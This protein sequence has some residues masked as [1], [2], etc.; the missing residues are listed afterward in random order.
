MS[1]KIPSRSQ[2]LFALKEIEKEV[3]RVLGKQQE[4]I[5][6][7][8]DI[9]VFRDYIASCISVGV[10]AID[11]ETNN[12]LDPLTCKLMGL[13]LY[14]PGLKAAYIPINHRDPET[15]IRLGVQLTE[16]DVNRELQKVLEAGIKIIMHNGKFDYEV[17]KCTCDICVEPHWD[18]MV[19]TRLLNEN[20]RYGLKEQYISKIDKTQEKYNIEKLFKDVQYADVKP[21]IFALYSAMDSFMTYKLYEYQ[22][23]LMDSEKNICKL[24]MDI[25]MP[26]VVIVA[27]MELCGALADLNY[28]QK[29]KDKYESKLA[30]IDTLLNDEILKL[31]SIISSWKVSESGLERERVFPPESVVART[32][33][34]VLEKR[35]PLLDPTSGL[36]Y[37]HGKTYASQ[38]KDPINLSSPKQLAILL[39]KV[40]GAN[41]VN[42]RKPNGTGKHEIEAIKYE[43]ELTLKLLEAKSKT[44]EAKGDDVNKLKGIASICELL[45]KRRQVEKIITTYLNPV[46]ALANHWS[47]GKI[48]FHLNQLGARTGRFTSGG[49]WKFYDDETPV[50]IQGMNAQNLPAENHEIRLMFKAE[51]GRIFVGGDISQQE[52]KITAHISLDEN[53]LQVYEEGKDIYASIAQSIFKNNYEDN[54]EFYDPEK[55]QIN[56]EGK[57]R[58]KVGKVIILATMYGMG[59][60]SVARKLGITT[61]EADE[62]L[63]AFYSQYEGVKKA[64]DFSVSYCKKYGFV[65]D[66]AGRKRRL[67][68]IQ[69]PKY[70]TMFITEP[71]ISNK[72]AE[73]ILRAV[74]DSKEKLSKEE[75]AELRKQAKE[76]NIIIVSNEEL[77]KKAERQ[78]FNA[79]I[80]GGAAT[81]T[82]MIMVMVA[83]DSLIKKL[84]GRIVFQIHDELIL[85]CPIENA[86]TIK[87]RLK[88]IMENSSTAVEIVLPMKCDMTTE[89]RWGEDTMT[90]EL[91]VAHQELIAEGAENPLDKL[92]EEFCNF[93][94]ESICKIIDSDNEVL[95]FEW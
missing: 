2:V 12:S 19:A 20:E 23:P 48:R 46:P 83:R 16:E 10:I 24:F 4:N 91:R 69:L 50:T 6:T 87:T 7:I 54:L 36:R 75:L 62:M 68:N 53:M 93:P 31:E 80:Q 76:N 29:L 17:L 44:S 73:R 81:L 43:A 85:D 11:T 63:N 3:I 84:G 88:A 21:E 58:R 89:T 78:S 70:Q 59:K 1:K 74:L 30:S 5:I 65:E 32:D 38:L 82:K 25:E 56:L 15:K 52:P 13:C 26:L 49:V 64:I 55:T 92:C 40:L 28:C 42:R 34:E 90:T 86:E 67:P 95:E 94:R 45:S 77:I 41:V 33:Q 61:A 14:A 71:T 37:R 39:Y 27:E 72:S 9:D 47:D 79:R 57:K 18:T 8:R 35:Y 60:R 51:P 66:V 22:L